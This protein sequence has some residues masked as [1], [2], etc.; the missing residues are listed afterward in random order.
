MT[1]SSSWKAAFAG[2]R[3]DRLLVLAALCVWIWAWGA[4]KDGVYVAVY[5]GDT[6]IGTWPLP[7]QGERMITVRGDLGPVRIVLSP[8]GVRI[9]HAPCP[10]KFCVASGWHRKSGDAAVCVPS[11]VVARVEAGAAALDA[12]VQ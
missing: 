7:P 8:A 12:V 3:E 10:H 11:R 1:K 6:R 5:H 2:K 4:G 9:A